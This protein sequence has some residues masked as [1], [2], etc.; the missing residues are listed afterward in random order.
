M[1]KSQALT[2]VSVAHADTEG[3]AS[4]FSDWVHEGVCGIPAVGVL[5]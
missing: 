2:T 1:A 4:C 3:I 5:A